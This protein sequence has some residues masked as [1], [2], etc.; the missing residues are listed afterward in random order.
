MMYEQLNSSKMNAS[1][2]RQ[3]KFHQL[4]CSTGGEKLKKLFGIIM[5]GIP[6]P[7]IHHTS[8]PINQKHFSK[9]KQ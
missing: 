9:Q 2:P 8:Y 7:T 1:N 3:L 4:S 5:D 6:K